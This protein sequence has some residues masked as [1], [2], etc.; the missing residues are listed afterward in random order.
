MPAVVG[1][2]LGIGVLGCA[3]IAL[4][5]F[6]P[7]V[8]RSD[9]AR[10]VGI[11]GRDSLKASSVARNYACA[12]MS[13][14]ELLQSEQVDLVYVPLPNHLHEE[15]T[16]DSLNRKKHVLCEKPLG[17]SPESVGRMLNAAEL[18]GRLLYENL[19]YLQHPQHAVIREML[20]TGRIGH[21]TGLNCVFTIPTLKQDN[22]RMDPT[23][24]GGAFH[25]LN[26]YPLSAA[27]Y[28]LNGEIKDIARCDCVRRDDMIMSMELEA[29]TTAGEM[30]SFSIAFGRPYRSYYE[31][32]GTRGALR[33]ERAFTPPADYGCSLDIC[34]NGSRETVIMAQHDHFQMTIDHVADLISE[35]RDF[36]AEHERALALAVAADRILRHARD[37]EGLQ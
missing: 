35:G 20:T 23:K 27:L 22:F 10:L 1:R 25:D 14:T 3:D 37:K 5:R 28:F 36:S 18:N 2:C 7:A 33:L 34:S 26:R 8:V 13:F 11:A 24:G 9:K 16:I 32:S 12:A 29:R 4:R 19:M 31:I 15:W 17:L 30:F 21:V 6:L